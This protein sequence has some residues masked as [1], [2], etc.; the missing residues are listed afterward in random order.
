MAGVC[1]SLPH[2]YSFPL[3]FSSVFTFIPFM[4]GQWNLVPDQ[5]L[6]WVEK[7]MMRVFG[8]S[9]HPE[10]WI[11]AAGESG[12]RNVVGSDMITKLNVA[13]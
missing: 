5:T 8:A 3:Y 9:S 10:P 4:E 2:S 13:D 6:L 7:S 1:D 12:N 11:A